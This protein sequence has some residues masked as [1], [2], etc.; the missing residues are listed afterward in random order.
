VLVVFFARQRKRKAW[1][2]TTAEYYRNGG[3]FNEVGM[4]QPLLSVPPPNPFAGSAPPGTP[5]TGT[6]FQ[7]SPF[8]PSPPPP[9]GQ[10]DPNANFTQDYQTTPYQTT[11]YQTPPYEST[12]Y[13]ST[14]YEST[15][16][17]TTPPPVGGQ[18]AN[19]YY[20]PNVHHAPPM[21]MPQAPLPHVP[22]L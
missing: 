3:R 4:V 15:L 9:P 6:S 2:R 7:S 19:T 10:Y 11:P 16:Y 12:P 18:Y 17:G 1:Y 8:Q 5:V 13:E 22:E 20:N 21:G 14:P